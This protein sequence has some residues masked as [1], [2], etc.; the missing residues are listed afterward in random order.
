MSD[1][2]SEMHR[3]MEKLQQVLDELGDAVDTR[4]TALRAEMGREFDEQ[5]R[6]SQEQAH[7]NQE[8]ERSVSRM[9]ASFDQNIAELQTDFVRRIRATSRIWQDLTVRTAEIQLDLERVEG[10][11][12][13]LGE[14][15]EDIEKRLAG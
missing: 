7:I 11:T 12:E 13:H 8:H 15:V 9:S 5:K 2:R 1:W 4:L 10:Q 14:R 6:L 3:E